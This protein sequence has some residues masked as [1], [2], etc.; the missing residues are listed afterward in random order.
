M[1]LIPHFVRYAAAF[2][3]AYKSGDYSIL[4]PYFTEDAVY[5]VPLPGVLGG[6]WEGRDAVLSCLESVTARF[7][8]H[9]A[10]REVRLVSGPREQDGSVW[11]R[12][13]AHYTAPGFP[14]LDF[15]LEETAWF[16]GERIKR[17]ADR[18]RDAPDAQR[19]AAYLRDHGAKLGIDVG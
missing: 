12:G 5:E 13:S 11:L 16:E 14:N 3:E 17:L 1:S 6:R 15:E 19:I 7:D 4:T 2:E 18:L 10:T 8:R 9:F